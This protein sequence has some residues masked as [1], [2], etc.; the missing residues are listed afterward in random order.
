MPAA[1]RLQGRQPKRREP[2]GRDLAAGDSQV[3]AGFGDPIVPSKA[4]DETSF[5]VAEKNEVR[6]PLVCRSDV[7][8]EV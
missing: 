5:I 8:P 7:Q 4:R 3:I 1:D 2:P 6:V